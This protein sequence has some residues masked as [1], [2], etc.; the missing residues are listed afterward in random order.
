MPSLPVVRHS[1]QRRG[2][3][4]TITIYGE[5]RVRPGICGN[6]AFA[7]FRCHWTLLSEMSNERWVRESLESG[8]FIPK[9]KN[10][11]DSF[12]RWREGTYDGLTLILRI[13]KEISN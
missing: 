2:E 7:L 13:N 3:W 10:N 11:K 1:Q 9:K 6:E 12:G 4:A 5:D 8:I